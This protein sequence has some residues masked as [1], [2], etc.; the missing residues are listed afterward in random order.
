MAGEVKR[1]GLRIDYAR[2]DRQARARKHEAFMAL[3]LEDRRCVM[4]R[5]DG[6]CGIYS[7]RPTSCRKYIVAS[8][9]DLCDTVKHK[10]GAV[11][12]LNAWQLE[13]MVSAAQTVFRTDLMAHLLKRV[14]P[15]E[16]A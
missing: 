1:V 4:L 2:L 13:A 3:S 11:A 15:G 10:G 6:L 7:A 14:L 8:D 9:P 12:I 16:K 5:D